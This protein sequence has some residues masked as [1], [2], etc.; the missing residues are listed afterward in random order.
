MKHQVSIVTTVLVLLSGVVFTQ[1]ALPSYELDKS[2][3]P[4]LPNNWVMGQMS[5]VAID[6]HDHVWLLHRPRFVPTDKQ[7]LAAPAVVEFDANGK[8]LQAWG[9]PGAGYEWPE[10]EHGIF[11]DD[12]DVVW[13]AGQAGTGAGV[14]KY[15]KA[16]ILKV[17]VDDDMVLKFTKQGKFLQQFGRQNRSGG[18]NDTKNLKEPADFVIYKKTNE[19]FVADGYGNRRVIVLDPDTFAFKRM[20][21][22]FGNTPIDAM[23]APLRPGLSGLAEPSPPAPAAAAPPATPAAG[24]RASAPKPA[25][26]PPQFGGP[27]HAIRVSNDGMVYVGDR[28]N[29]RVQVFTVDGKYV[30]QLLTQSGPGALSLSPDAQQQFL[31]VGEGNQILVVDRKTLKVLSADRFGPRGTVHPHHMAIDS[32]GNIYTAELDYGTQRF[33]RR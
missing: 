29:N 1:G 7:K 12:K 18:N 21:G 27:V 30:T 32:K 17:P 22:A 10:N 33:V 11:V 16:G 20:W 13:I 2:W 8:F 28:S 23:P 31:F 5:S 15:K 6:S 14:V 3:P 26:G 19:L 25:E 24:G 9:G 4:K